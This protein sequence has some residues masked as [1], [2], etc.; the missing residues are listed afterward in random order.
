VREAA[1]QTSLIRLA[2]L[3][4]LADAF[5]VPVCKVKRAGLAFAPILTYLEYVATMLAE[6]IT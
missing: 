4:Q 2:D 6:S 3:G 1:D 5:V